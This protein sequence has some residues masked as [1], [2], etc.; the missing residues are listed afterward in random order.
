MDKSARFNFVFDDGGREDAG[1]KGMAGD[2]V[3]RSVAIAT[4]EDYKTIYEA[5]WAIVR[6]QREAGVK[7]ADKVSPRSGV[8]RGVYEQY[9]FE[10][11]W[12]WH[13]QMRVGQKAR[14]HVLPYELPREDVIVRLSGH[15]SAIVNGEIHDTFDPSREGTRTVY[16]FFVRRE[17][18]YAKS[19]RKKAG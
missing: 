19:Q 4:G 13:T 8:P 10:N 14:T 15:M 1:Y 12:E 3:V 2:C 16:G 9:L 17:G 7:G 6:R 5:M 11:G 18:A